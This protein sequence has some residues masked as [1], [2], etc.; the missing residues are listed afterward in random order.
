M[1]PTDFIDSHTV[2]ADDYEVENFLINHTVDVLEKHHDV[3]ICVDIQEYCDGEKLIISIK[4]HSPTGNA[5][6]NIYE[7]HGFRFERWGLNRF[8]GEVFLQESD[9]ES[10]VTISCRLIHGY[11]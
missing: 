10:D 2:F 6:Q 5:R 1:P 11:V 7:G 9:S 8:G 3:T 4:S